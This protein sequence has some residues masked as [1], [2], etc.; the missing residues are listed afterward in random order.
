M[1]YQTTNYKAVNQPLRSIPLIRPVSCLGPSFQHDP[2]AVARQVAART[3]KLARKAV[4]DAEEA[5]TDAK[6]EVGACNR[7]R[8]KDR[9]DRAIVSDRAGARRLSAA[10]GTMNRRRGAIL[11]AKRALHTARTAA[12]R[13]AD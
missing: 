3:L 13:L 2:A 8:R 11:Q 7:M 5:Y 9:H 4:V 1:T 10:F 6:A 12:A